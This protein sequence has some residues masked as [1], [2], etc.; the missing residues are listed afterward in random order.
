MSHYWGLFGAGVYLN[1]VLGVWYNGSNWNIFI[2]DPTKEFP[3]GVS[4]DIIVASRET[5]A[6]INETTLAPTIS[7]F[8]NPANTQVSFISSEIIENVTI[9]NTLGQNV[10]SVNENAT[11]VQMDISWLGTGAY[12]AKVKAGNETQV[13]RLIKK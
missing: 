7:L 10:L 2:E 5:T 9:L 6:G 13:L 8:P 4:F 11:N 12:L 1:E 3:E